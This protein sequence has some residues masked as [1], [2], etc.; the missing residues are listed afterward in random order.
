[1]KQK[2]KSKEN[3][4]LPPTLDVVFQSL[5]G[6][7]G[8]ESITTSFLEAILNTKINDIDLS[9]NLVL[10]R[11]HVDD[12]LGILDVIARL[13][14][15]EYCN[16]EM[17][18]STKDNIKER[19]LFYWSKLYTKQMKKSN[20]YSTLNKTIGILIADFNVDGLEGLEYCTSWRIIEEKYRKTIL[21]EKLELYIIE[22]PKIKNLKN[23]K[24]ALLDWLFFL[25]NPKSERVFKKMKENKQL[26]EA[27][28]KLEQ[29][30]NDE[31]MQRLAE[32]RQKAIWD[33]NTA[34]NA[35]F[36]KR[37]RSW[38]KD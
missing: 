37:Y 36:R 23:E 34:I 33:K 32:L 17:Q 8:S 29:I 25:V 5:F 31:Q 22:L 14:G 24:S 1:M 35:G 21:T 27:Y 7:I 16:I 2:T 3:N 11:E 6:E 9:K 13:N 38:L 18:C 30:S 15:N 12:K 19:M 10:R 20:D 4:I 28:N 26:K